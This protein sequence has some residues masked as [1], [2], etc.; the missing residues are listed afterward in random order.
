MRRLG[1]IRALDGL[2]GV[3]V[4]LVVVDHIQTILVPHKVTVDSGPFRGAFLG[5]DIFF[6][7]SGFLITSLLLGEQI[8]RSRIRFGAFYGRRALR[9][10]PALYLLLAAHVVYTAITRQSLSTEWL[11]VRGALLYVSN[12]TWKWDGFR[13]APGLGQLWSLSIE[14]QFYLVWPALLLLFFGVRRR[15]EVVVTV[16][17]A[18]IVAIALHRA[19]MWHNGTNWLFL[20]LRTDTRADSLLV[21]ALL[22]QLWIRGWSPRRGVVASAHVA[23]VLLFIAVVFARSE[24]VF[25]YYGGY[26]LFAIGVA[27]VIFAVADGRWRGAGVLEWAPLRA[28]GRVSY[29]L[30]LWHLPVFYA[31]N[32]VGSSWGAPARVVVALPLSAFFTVASWTLLERPILDWRQRRR[33]IARSGPDPR[34]EPRVWTRSPNS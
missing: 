13:S 26:T 5:V 33:L 23:S 28:V 15:T 10:L 1:H 4:L 7:L 25:L 2:R 24:K 8:D 14:E 21:G 18:A 34:E 9:L 17:A 30:Y 6:V 19:V 16:M 11:T 22:A 29:G 20:Y 32:R 12:W 3:A 31:V 27:V